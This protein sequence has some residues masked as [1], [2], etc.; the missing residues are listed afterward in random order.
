[1]AEQE[2]FSRKERN[3]ILKA[4]EGSGVL[5]KSQVRVWVKKYEKALQRAEKA[6]KTEKKEQLSESKISTKDFYVFKAAWS[7][8]PGYKLGYKI[9]LEELAKHEDYEEI[10][11]IIEQSIR[12][13]IAYKERSKKKGEFVA[14]WPHMKNWIKER[15]WEQV[16]PEEKE[17]V[18]HRK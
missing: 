4:I 1:M 2:S 14:P 11:K 13:E 15:R 6:P 18:L 12:D 3:R 9:L 16:F 8:Y 10:L 17:P 5:S 7:I